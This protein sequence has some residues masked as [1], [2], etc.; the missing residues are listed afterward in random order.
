MLI[1][2]KELSYSWQIS[3]KECECIHLLIVETFTDKIL[4]RFRW[5]ACQIDTLSNCLNKAEL[6]LALESLPR[7]L[8]ET[9]ERILLGINE[10]QV[11]YALRLLR[12]GSVS[13][14]VRF[15]WMNSPKLQRSIRQETLAMIQMR[16]LKNPSIFYWSVGV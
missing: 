3:P 1:C 8:G 11:K 2:A 7:S 15:S 12:N 6:R 14:T 10:M 9:Y 16:S 13:Q 4:R 5:A